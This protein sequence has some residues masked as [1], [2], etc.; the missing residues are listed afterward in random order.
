MGVF[1]T[2]NM[3]F[4][5]LYG[6]IAMVLLLLPTLLFAKKIQGRVEDLETCGPL[7]CLMEHLM[8]IIAAGMLIFA[9][10]SHRD[11][12]FLIAAIVVLALYYLL[13]ARFV[14]NSSYHP[15]FFTKGLIGIPAPIHL[16]NALFFILISIYLGNDAALFVSIVY[17]VCHYANAL[18]MRQDLIKEGY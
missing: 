16:M 7:V 10:F 15:E 13:W 12:Y 4:F 2:E 3:H 5:S 6:L 18:K 9:G 17:G 11:Q 8:R 1:S 14:S